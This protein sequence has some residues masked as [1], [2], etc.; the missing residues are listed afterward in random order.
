MPGY[1]QKI[2]AVMRGDARGNASFFDRFLLLASRGYAAVQHSRAFLYQQGICQSKQLPCKIISIGN[3][4]VGGTGKTPMTI[5]LAERLQAH[6]Y[7][8]AVISRGYRA[9]AEK[10]GGVVSDG[11]NILLNSDAAGDESYLMALHLKGIPVVIGRNRFAAGEMTI[12][13]FNP[14]I[15]LLDDAFQHI[16]LKRNIDLVLLDAAKPLGNSHLLPRGVLREPISSLERADAFILTRSEKKSQRH[17]SAVKLLQAKSV[18]IRPVFRSCHVPYWYKAKHP[19]RNT[20]AGNAY[21][22][23]N[24]HNFDLAGQRVLAF[25][26]IARNDEFYRTLKKR[27]C[28]VLDH[29]CYPDHHRYS[30]GDLDHIAESARQTGADTL[31]TTEKDFVRV[32]SKVTDWSIDIIVIGVGISLMDDEDGFMAF[33]KKNL[34]S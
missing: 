2:E 16:K 7:R 23:R 15:I 25:S 30:D 33:I 24:G 13:Q 32:A 34:E 9:D 28:N 29:I 1:R 26:G 27:Q 12:S 19:E 20:E 11:K 8:V 3:I 4:S 31:V 22:Q 10:S 5:Y 17:E 6:G 14:D 21:V 18:P